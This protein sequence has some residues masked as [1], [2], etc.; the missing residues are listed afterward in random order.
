MA[1]I[2]PS[3]SLDAA[4]LQ[5]TKEKSGFRGGFSLSKGKATLHRS[6]AI[7]RRSLI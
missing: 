2:F 6:T 4:L 1:L 7:K 5:R 3:A